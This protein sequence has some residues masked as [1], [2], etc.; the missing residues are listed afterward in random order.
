M[1]D[2]PV[3]IVT[4]A[5]RGIGLATA[6][7]LAPRGVRREQRHDQTAEVTRSQ[8]SGLGGVFHDSPAEAGDG[9]IVVH[10]YVEQ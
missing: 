2:K 8:H 6:G 10:G 5:A 4:G 3:A 7:E 1:T 9:N